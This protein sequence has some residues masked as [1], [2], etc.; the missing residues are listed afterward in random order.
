MIHYSSH[1]DDWARIELRCKYKNRT[2]YSLL[3][4]S[5]EYS[6]THYINPLHNHTFR[7]APPALQDE[8]CA[9]LYQFESCEQALGTVYGSTEFGRRP[10]PSMEENWCNYGGYQSE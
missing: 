1:D 9:I 5:R 2:L 4:R 6:I 8:Q 10:T 7:T 3:Q